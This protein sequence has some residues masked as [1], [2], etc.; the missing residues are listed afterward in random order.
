MLRDEGRRAADAF[1]R[2]HGDD[3]GRRST[4]DLDAPAGRSLSDGPPRHPARPRPADLAGLSRLERAAAG[5]RRGAASPRPSRGEPLLAHWTQTFMGSAAQFLAQ[6]FPLFL[7]GALF[8]KLMEDSGSVAAIA[9]FMT[10]RL[11]AAPRDA[12]GGARRRAG[13]LW[14]RQPVRR[15]LRAGADGAGAVP[16]RRHSAPADAGGDRARHLDLHHVG[17]AGHARDPERDPDAV[18]RHHAV[19]RARPRHHRLGDH[20]GLRPVVARPRAKPRPGA[21][22]RAMATAPMS[23]RGAVAEDQIVRE[24]ATTAR[25]FDP[26]EIRHG[27]HSDTAP[28]IAL[29]ALPLVVVVGVNLLMSLV[30]LPRLDFS[31]LAEERW[32]AHVAVGGRRR[33]GGGGGARGRRSWC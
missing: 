3:L 19:R 20:A 27:R 1:L 11:G 12:G 18:L 16:R 2:A 17:A 24:R 29:A 30:V 6:F 8:G 15:L 31:F 33:L 14:R 7:L 28:P 10:E 32:G 26:A 4:L 25:E 21:P 5:A 13:H 9:R 22:A 23:I